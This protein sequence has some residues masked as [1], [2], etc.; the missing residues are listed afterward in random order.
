MV[1]ALGSSGMEREHL[2]SSDRALRLKA[3]KALKNEIIGGLPVRARGGGRMCAR[4]AGRDGVPLP[5]AAAP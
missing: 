1:Y 5:D 2:R 3:L 4:R